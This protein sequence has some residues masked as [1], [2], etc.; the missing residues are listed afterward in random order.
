[1][2]PWKIWN[3]LGLMETLYSLVL[4]VVTIRLEQQFILSYSMEISFQKIIPNVEKEIEPYQT[5]IHFGFYV[6]FGIK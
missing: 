6:K 4:E 2:F 3:Q 1:M 5:F